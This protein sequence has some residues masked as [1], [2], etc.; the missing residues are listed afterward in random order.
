MI[1]ALKYR[2]L[3]IEMRRVMGHTELTC[4]GIVKVEA[5]SDSVVVLAAHGGRLKV[6]GR[7]LSVAVFEGR[8][9]KVIGVILGVELL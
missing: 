3:F 7:A 4:A 9:V 2:G 6:W 5:L 1:D 8:A